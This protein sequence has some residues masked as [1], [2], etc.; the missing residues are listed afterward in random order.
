MNH[1][2]KPNL[3]VVAIGLIFLGALARLLPH[4]P[5]FAPIGALALFGG[6]RL[7]RWWGILI[8]LGAMLLSDTFLGFHQGMWH[9]YGAFLLV[10]GIGLLIRSRVS[11]PN[12]IGASLLASTVFFLVTNFGVWAEG[13]L[14]PRTFDGLLQ[15]YIMAIPF[16]GPTLLSDLLYSGAIFGVYA[17]VTSKSTRNNLVSRH[18]IRH[19]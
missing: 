15:S 12:L 17:V 13:L 10:Y 9:V 1:A 14:Y 6:A 16:F 19:S 11:A 3:T 4:L 7:P 18:V 8:V 5:N 2:K